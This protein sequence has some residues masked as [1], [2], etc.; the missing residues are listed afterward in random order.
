[1]KPNF[2]HILKSTF[3]IYLTTLFQWLSIYSVEWR[4]DKWLVNWKGRLWP[5]FQTLY[6]NLPGRTKK[7]LEK[8]HQ[9]SRSEDPDLN[10]RLRTRFRCL[11]NRRSTFLHK[12]EYRLY[13]NLGHTFPLLSLRIFIPHGS[14]VSVLLLLFKGW[15]PT[16]RPTHWKYYWSIVLPRLSS[17]HFWFTH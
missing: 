14:Y 7:N 10:R 5:T 12:Q 1:M 17:N 6:Q 4:R 9:N 11:N 3:V 8:L 2:L 15:Y 16:R 13:R